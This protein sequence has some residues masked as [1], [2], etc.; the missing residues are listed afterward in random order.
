M[1]LQPILLLL[2]TFTLILEFYLL[3]CL[4]EFSE[5]DN[6]RLLNEFNS[7]T[8]IQLSPLLI[9]EVRL[10]LGCDYMTVHFM[11]EFYEM[12]GNF[13]ATHLEF[14]ERC[15]IKLVLKVNLLMTDCCS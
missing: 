8:S 2:G 4:H 9:D 6:T 3:L 14:A 15:L 12:F 7:D 10:D 1:E 13:S 11:F 5:G